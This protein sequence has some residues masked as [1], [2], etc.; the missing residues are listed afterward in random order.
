MLQLTV[1]LASVTVP[2]PLP[3]KESERTGLNRAETDFPEL[4]KTLQFGE[5]VGQPADPP[6]PANVAV[7]L[8]RAVSVTVELLVKFAEQV[9]PQLI[10]AGE[11]IT[12][13]VLIGPMVD[14]VRVK[15]ALAELANIHNNKTALRYFNLILLSFR[16][17]LQQI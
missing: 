2:A 5:F 11:L 7:L 8:C 6:Q 15:V 17:L 10:P 12:T 16:L 3:N 14:T 4:I 13:A 1:P 9:G